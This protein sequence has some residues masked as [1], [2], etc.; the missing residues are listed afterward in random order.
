MTTFD[1]IYDSKPYRMLAFG[2]TVLA[3][4]VLLKSVRKKLLP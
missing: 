2:I 3:L 4:V 1:R